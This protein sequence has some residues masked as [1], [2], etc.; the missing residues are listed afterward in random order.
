MLAICQKNH[1]AL[2]DLEGLLEIQ[3][4]A[5]RDASR[6]VMKACMIRR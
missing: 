5:D 4:F 6:L 1:A 3:A 2:E